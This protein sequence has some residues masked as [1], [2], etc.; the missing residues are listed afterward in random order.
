MHPHQLST[1]TTRL[2]L[3]PRPLP[4]MTIVTRH[5]LLQPLRHRTTMILTHIPLLRHQLIITR[6][7]LIIIAYPRLHLTNISNTLTIRRPHRPPPNISTV[8]PLLPHHH[9]RLPLHH[10]KRGDLQHRPRHT[11]R[12]HI[13]HSI[14]SIT[15]PL[16]LPLNTIIPTSPLLPLQLPLPHHDMITAGMLRPHP[17]FNNSHNSHNSRVDT[18]I[19]TNLITTNTTIPRHLHRHRLSPLV[20]Q[21][22]TVTIACTLRT[23]RDTLP[24][25]NRHLLRLQLNQCMAA[26]IVHKA[27]AGVPGTRGA[28]LQAQ[29]HHNTSTAAL[30]PRS[31]PGSLKLRVRTTA[32]TR[33]RHPHPRRR[34]AATHTTS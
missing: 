2:R 25:P 30:L 22:V 29:C 8:H 17:P 6:L 34:T 18:R 1:R 27:R 3:L 16:R 19:T 33:A 13:I 5:R 12:M 23:T 32:D 20:R 10:R 14:S 11:I 26:N 4:H 9:P 28:T 15:M 31:R 24:K 21:L 7:P